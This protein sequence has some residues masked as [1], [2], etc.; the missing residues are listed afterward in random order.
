MAEKRKR[1]HDSHGPEIRKK[2][3]KGFSVGPANLPEGLYKRKTQKIKES[4]IQR[5]QIKKNYARLKKQNPEQDLDPNLD[6][7][8]EPASLAQS[9]PEEGESAASVEPTPTTTPHPDRQDLM[10]NEP[11]SP[12]APP[13]LAESRGG[14]RQR[15]AKNLP[16]R[17]E[18]EAAQRQRAEAEERQRA[19]EQA[20]RERA[21]K[22]EERERFRKAM[23]KAR[24]GGLNGQRK[25]GRESAVLLE[26]VKRMVG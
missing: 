23:A 8:P 13:P 1:A 4:L 19:R 25:L 5:A 18:H 9:R 20:E 26:K 10:D 16:F 6:R 15:K 2:T 24:T 21:Q 3:K 22:R 11:P 14:R 17:K 7:I 12:P